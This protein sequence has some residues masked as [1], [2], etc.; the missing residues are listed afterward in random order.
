MTAADPSCCIKQ[1]EFYYP[2]KVHEGSYINQW[3]VTSN[4][5][6]ARLD[7]LWRYFKSGVQSSHACCSTV[8]ENCEPSKIEDLS[9]E[10]SWFCLFVHCT[11]SYLQATLHSQILTWPAQLSVERGGHLFLLMTR[12]LRPVEKLAAYVSRSRSAAFR[13]CHDSLAHHYQSLSQKPPRTTLL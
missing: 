7:A 1:R 4:F 13:T 10:V 2:I 3:N 9:P 8:N 6:T 11:P 5:N 12:S